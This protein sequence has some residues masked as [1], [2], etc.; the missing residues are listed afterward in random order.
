MNE[1]NYITVD[2]NKEHVFNVLPNTIKQ[3]GFRLFGCNKELG[4]MSFSGDETLTYYTHIVASGN[5]RCKIMFAP[6][7]SSMK[8]RNAD[9]VMDALV[10]KV[11]D[12]LE[13]ICEKE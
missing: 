12:E 7:L 8:D 6:G 11:N 9:K 13:K 1:L 10:D 4:L 5:D 2:C 3:L